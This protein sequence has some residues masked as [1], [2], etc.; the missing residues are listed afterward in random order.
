M[1]GQMY[2]FKLA[3][4]GVLASLALPVF[5]DELAPSEQA[6]K[7]VGHNS[8]MKSKVTPMELLSQGC[9]SCCRNGQCERAFGNRLPGTCCSTQ[10]MSCCPSFFQGQRYYCAGTQCSAQPPVVG[11]APAPAP[12]APAVT[13][14]NR[15]TGGSCRFFGCSQDRGPTSCEGGIVSGKKC[16]C[17]EGHCAY[18]G[19]CIKPTSCETWT[20]GTCA[21]FGCK[22]SR[23]DVKCQDGKCVCKTGACSVDGVCTKTCEK[24]TGGTCSW[25]GCKSS[26][27]AVCKHGKCMCRRGDC[28]FQGACEDGKHVEDLFALAMNGTAMINR[29]Q[30]TPTDFN[31][32][33]AVLTTSLDTLPDIDD[34]VFVYFVLSVAMA[35]LTVASTCIAIRRR[36]SASFSEPLLDGSA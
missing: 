5:T 30:K 16:M 11:P 18:D 19:K 3:Y 15:D 34:P 24:D 25:F 6:L 12:Y 10:P 29:A 1:A 33:S 9:M 31:S 17:T 22:S 4:A 23:G 32:F 14:C 36:A 13:V 28:S 35:M 20:P 21:V 27:N 8:T 7:V 26:R 2:A